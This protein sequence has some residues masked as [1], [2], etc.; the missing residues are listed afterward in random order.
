VNKIGFEWYIDGSIEQLVS[1]I[2]G[3]EIHSWVVG[4]LGSGNFGKKKIRLT[5]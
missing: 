1:L 4:F 2:P 3:K 5:S